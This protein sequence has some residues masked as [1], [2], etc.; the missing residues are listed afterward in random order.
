MQGTQ[1]LFLSTAPQKAHIYNKYFNDFIYL[2]QCHE[3]IRLGSA[4]RVQKMF[5]EEILIHRFPKYCKKLLWKDEIRKTCN[6]NIWPNCKE[7]L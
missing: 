6:E 1:L 5:G 2:H 4:Q 3:I 7:E